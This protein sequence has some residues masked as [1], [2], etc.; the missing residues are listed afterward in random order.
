MLAR[1]FTAVP[2]CFKDE[3]STKFDSLPSLDVYLPSSAWSRSTPITQTFSFSGRLSL[4]D[5]ASEK[6]PAPVPPATW[7][8]TSAPAAYCAAAI[9][10]P[11]AASPNEPA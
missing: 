8:T 6:T 4:S 5:F 10:L 2:T 7:Y 3:A 9:V 1:S 11:L